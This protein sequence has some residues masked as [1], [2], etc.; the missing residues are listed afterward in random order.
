MNA[1][2]TMRRVRAAAALTATA[3]MCVAAIV[4][5]GVR[6]AEVRLNDGGVWVTNSALRLVAHLNYPA[7]QL[8]S[9]LRAASDSFN[10]HQD[11]E[12]VFVSDTEQ[13]TL[14]NVDVATT[15]LGAAG[16]FTGL[17][18]SFNAG[19]VAV[20]DGAGG[21]VWAL[22]SQDYT[23][24]SPDDV[25]PDITGMPGVLTT[26]GLDGSVHAVSATAS[27]VTSIVPKGSVHDT[28]SEDLTGMGKDDTLQ[29]A[30]VGS[31]P[32]VLD[33]DTAT[34][35]LPGGHTQQVQ[36]ADLKLQESGPESD[37]VVVASDSALM[38]IPLE[39]GDP[40]VT[41]TGSGSGQPSR[42]A[43]HQ[44]CAYGAWAGTGDF[45]RDCAGDSSDVS[46]HVDSLAT[47]SQAVFRVN[48]DVIVLND[49][50]SGGLWLPD[51]DMIQVD[52]WDQ[53]DSQLESEDQDN[54][55]DS[56]DDTQEQLLPDRSEQNTPPVAVDDE[57]GVRAGR[58]AILP[59]LQNDSDV[60]GDFMTASPVSQPSLGEV[61]VARDGAAL[62]I[63][64]PVGQTGSSTFE[65]EVSDGRGGT[66][67]ARVTLSVHGDDVNA[68]PIQTIVPSVSLASGSSATVNALSNWYDPDGDP[69]YLD[70]AVAPEGITARAR[71]NGTVAVSV[72]D[73]AA[74][75]DS[76]TLNVSDGHD[77]GT[78]SLSVTVKDSGNEPPVANTDHLVVRSGSSATAYP[79]ANDTDPNGDTLRLAQIDAAPAGISATMDGTLGSVTVEGNEPGT[80][81]LGY[82]VTDG[83]ATAAGVIRIDVTDEDAKAPP[84][85]EDDLG[86]LPDGGQVLVDLLA[87]DSDPTGGVLTVQSVSVPSSSSL[88]VALENHQVAR[89]T[90]PRGLTGPQTFTYTVSNGYDSAQATVTVIP[91]PALTGNEPPELEDDEL[92]VRQGDV[93]SVSVLANDSSPAGLTLTV[94]PELKHEIGEDLA[95]VF[96]SDN[97]VRVR[98]G[99][100]A[101]SG[102]IIY[103]VR[104]S[105]GNVAS[106][107]VKLTVVAMDENTNTAPKPRDV[108]ARTVAG[109]SVDIPIPLEGI[110]AEGDSVTLVGLGSAPKLGTVATKG[111]V[112]T[113]TAAD[114]ASGTDA[115]TYVV[116]DRLGKQATG[117]IRVGVAPRAGTNQD[118]VAVTD[119]T[120]V[121]PGTKVAV[122]VLANDVDPDGDDLTL[123][124]DAITP[125]DPSVQVSARSGRI[126]VVA[127]EKEGSYAITYG[128]SDGVGGSAT[129]LLTVVVR[130][131]APLLA[132][133]ARDDEVSEADVQTATGG[134]V[135]VPVLKN[136]EDPDG[137][138]N[139]DAITSPDQG[140]SVGGDGTVAVTL[141]ESSQILVYTVTDPT[142]LAAS[143]VIRVPGTAVERP[144][145]DTRTVPIKVK[146][147]VATDIPINDHIT[148]RSGRTV[149]ITSQDKV[150]AGLGF[151]GGQL[152]KDATTLTYTSTPE[153]SGPT[154][155]TLEVT[156]GSD[157]NDST[158][159][160]ATLSLP[161]EV[162]P[163]K[164][165]P[166]VF[167]P[168]ALQVAAGEKAVT[169]DLSQMV[170]DPDKDD[171]RRMTYRIEGGSPEGI[172]ASV[173]GSVLSVSADADREK[174]SA[175]VI[176]VGVDDGKGGTTRGDVPVTVVSS[177]RP[178]VQTSEAQV[179][180]N[181]SQTTTVDIA[182]YVTNPFPDKGAVSLVGSP[183]A[184][185]GGR[186]SAS[187]TTISLTADSGFSGTFTVTYR[188]V[189]VTK[190]PAREVQGVITA[191]VRDRPGAPANAS[192]TSNGPGTAQVSWSA[193][194]AN[195]ASI[196]GFTVTDHTQGDSVQCGLVTS[197]LVPNRKNGVEHTF[198]V[199][200]TNE[201]GTSDPSNQTTTMIDI[202]PE[203]PGTPVLSAGDHQVT[204][205]WSASHNEG[206]AI[207]EYT[208]NLSPGGSK[209]FA[210]QGGGTQTQ[211]IT[212]LTNGVEYT[213]TVQATNSK[214]S[215]PVSQV[216]PAAVPY[217]A[218][219]AV[220]SV[221]AQ[222]ASLGTGSGQVATVNVSWTPPS[223]TNG[224]AVEYYTVTGGGVTKQVQAS[225][226]TSTSLE[227][228][229]FSSSQVQF[230][231]TATNDAS[232]AA[233]RTSPATTTSTWVVGQPLAPTISSVG[234]TGA[235]NQATISWSPS[236]SGQGWSASE[237]SYEWSA[238]GGWAPLSGS[239]I[240]GNGLTNGQAAT[241]QI[242]AVGSKTGSTATSAAS[243]GVAVTP[244]GSPKMPAVSATGNVNDVT[245]SWDGRNA[246]NGRDI[247][248][249]NIQ[250]TDSSSKQGTNGSVTQ[251]SGRDQ[252]KQIRAQACY[253]D[254]N[255]G[256]WSTY[257]S[258]ATWS[259]SY[260]DSDAPSGCSASQ[261]NWANANPGILGK[262]CGL[263][264]M[265]VH[266]FNPNSNV[267]CSFNLDQGGTKSATIT[268]NGD[269]YGEWQSDT[270][271]TDGGVGSSSSPRNSATC[272]QR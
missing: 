58:T 64:V 209:T 105:M 107:T 270:A 39:G 63:A 19:T 120:Q 225:S 49:I 95:T 93:G 67:K 253:A 245:L 180:L 155:V 92:V 30:A 193:G 36:G 228:V 16:D 14:T 127:P 182:S 32:V 133:I 47:A 272:V 208:L 66:A 147:G 131:D 230:S 168:T 184:G 48:R 75:K 260:W 233:A 117:R 99:Q 156:D 223:D 91:K 183:Q 96:L 40:E 114:T 200:A 138:I 70:S 179:T 46:M 112:M 143:A 50:E 214:G 55:D 9:G 103:T 12:E 106:A 196:S 82:V 85:A 17:A 205:T 122:A 237:L 173:S 41:P 146:A 151:A 68:P 166:P 174:G 83:P 35:Y 185:S 18:T 158:G 203:V 265:K 13:S 37:R 227:G 24:F 56:V 248:Y 192:V 211:V 111:S 52:N 21:R 154:S 162:E 44:A 1:S 261:Q 7:R 224:R 148:T 239:T 90:A 77:M 170:T 6:A 240:S 178:L 249:V 43:F 195:G 89:I 216:G 257:A 217:G 140:V 27:K 23:G 5:P 188:V 264:R 226:G 215:S 4:N 134:T 123:V 26:V 20:A 187:G 254:G 88:V 102:K 252:T 22:S 126:V 163:G 191:T 266:F 25:D 269:G 259:S 118:P 73:H 268:T 161:I 84:T 172:S 159:V 62:Q 109:R 256:S 94:E 210:P 80:Y 2:P 128:I 258:G 65:Y 129:G 234:A 61:T 121:R 71:E 54:D 42:P 194:A 171:P 59:V 137:D 241:V 125:Q 206:S 86:V 97:V 207:T 243:N 79:L 135:R 28:S 246:G 244:Y 141:K 152:V 76:V 267:T 219:G 165:R 177:S 139:D 101:G 113:Y 160:V 115:F 78:G 235:D 60:D 45:I 236:A 136:D 271:S 167:T 87:N 242:R 190:D 150:S 34:L 218:P 98:G 124:E 247:S 221:S 186:A 110:D 11:G 72:L 15:T 144:Q 201:V 255:C 176:T 238:G 157:L 169:G 142:G 149:R 132:P 108:T 119:L 10:V 153:F 263:V 53:I 74:G 198:S 8:D 31:D 262:T 100:R 250:T 251:G 3:A 204:V 33:T 231:V 57:F 199:T 81:Y 222:Y 175:G 212:G 130:A 197:C 229:G 145:V 38:T 202:E 181:A 232:N 104:D 189:D 29:I 51:L 116:Q 220:G 164:N 69:F 213:A